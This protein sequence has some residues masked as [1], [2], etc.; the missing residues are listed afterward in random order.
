MHT[1][2]VKVQQ[3]ILDEKVDELIFHLT[4]GLEGAHRQIENNFKGMAAAQH[5]CSAM[6]GLL[7]IASLQKDF[8]GYFRH[9]P[10]EATTLLNGK[11]ISVN[12]HHKVYEILKATLLNDKNQLNNTE[13]CLKVFAK[14]FAVNRAFFE[15]YFHLWEQVKD[16]KLAPSSRV[17]ERLAYGVLNLL[18]L[19][20]EKGLLHHAVYRPKEKDSQLL[21]RYNQNRVISIDE[22]LMDGQFESNDFLNDDNRKVPCIKCGSYAPLLGYEQEEPEGKRF[23]AYSFCCNHCGLEL[24]DQKDLL[25]AGIKPIYEI[26]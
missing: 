9:F 21:Q 4:E 16:S 18:E 26:F 7:D 10:R 12:E 14:E 13:H 24:F 6:G 22:A 23:I 19:L 20:V 11:D 25:L 3:K 8:S 5:L 1:L 17:I 15:A 2:L